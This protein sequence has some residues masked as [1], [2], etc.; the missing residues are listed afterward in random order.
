MIF[1]HITP[2]RFPTHYAH[3][4]L[5]LAASTL[6]TFIMEYK[7]QSRKRKFL[8]GPMGYNKRRQGVKNVGPIARMAPKKITTEVKTVDILQQAQSF[9]N[10][11][12]IWLL[13]GCAAGTDAWERTGRLT[14]LKS[15]LFTLNVYLIDRGAANTVGQEELRCLLIYDKRP[16]GAT[17]TWPDLIQSIDRSGTGQ[18]GIFDRPNLANSDRFTILKDWSIVTAYSQAAGAAF[19][20]ASD[21]AQLMSTETAD[22]KWKFYK[23]LKGIQTRYL[24][25]GSDIAS[26]SEGS[27]YA[28]FLGTKATAN[29]N[30]GYNIAARVRYV[31]A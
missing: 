25:A 17:F 27:L 4:S 1:T 12:S 24:T 9:N 5:A 31:D 16:N 30:Y 2:Y 29:S 3:T 18:S 28:V 11:V 23:N 15:L 7:Q 10:A 26:I 13:N 8:T 6:S 20:A 19:G 21:S 14:N 22:F